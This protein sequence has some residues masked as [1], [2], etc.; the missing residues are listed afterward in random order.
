MQDK[1]IDIQ[2]LTMEEKASLAANQYIPVHILE[3]LAKYGDYEVWTRLASNPKTPSA[4]LHE[5]AEKRK[6]NPRSSILYQEIVNNPNVAEKTLDLIS[7]IDNENAQVIHIALIDKDKVTENR[8]K[9]IIDSHTNRGSSV[10]FQHLVDAP[11]CTA[12]IM[13]YLYD[14]VAKSTTYHPGEK[15]NIFVDIYFCDAT[16]K[17]LKAKIA[18]LHS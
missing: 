11:E 3:D 5:F 8:L 14:K 6:T 12:E 16:P 18:T 7:E 1:N 17:W 15:S 10:I 9:K 2:N 13:M 4:L